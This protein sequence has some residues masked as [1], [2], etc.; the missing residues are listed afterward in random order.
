MNNVRIVGVTVLCFGIFAT[1]G[2]SQ[3]DS[4]PQLVESALTEPGGVPSYLQP[5]ITER[6]DPSERID[7]EMSW[8]SPDNWRRTIHSQEFSQTLTVNGDK[9]LEQD[10]DDYFPC[11]YTDSGDGNG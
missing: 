5:V 6:A 2:L 9:V 10:S 8:V 3:T 11:R 1:N 4:R 7:V